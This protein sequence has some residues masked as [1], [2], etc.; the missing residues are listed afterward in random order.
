MCGPDPATTA[1][2]I[3]PVAA[4]ARIPPFSVTV[5]LPNAEPE[6]LATT[7]VPLFSVAPPLMLLD[8]LVR[9]SVPLLVPVPT[10]RLSRPL[11]LFNCPSYW[12]EP[13]TTR[14][15]VPVSL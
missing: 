8:P 14:P 3:V 12:P 10:V 2:P 13:V 5:P 11:P 9:T 6:V 7:S 4:E 1:P 15:A